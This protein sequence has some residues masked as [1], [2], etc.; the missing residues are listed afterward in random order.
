MSEVLIGSGGVLDANQIASLISQNLKNGERAKLQID[1]TRSPTAEFVNWLQDRL[2]SENIPGVQVS[3]GSP[4]LNISWIHYNDPVGYNPDDP[5]GPVMWIQV[6]MAVAAIIVSIAVIIALVIGWRIYKDIP[7]IVKGPLISG[8]LI[9]G[10]I[11][12]LAIA[13]RKFIPEKRR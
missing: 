11:L 9:A 8:V 3:T 4:I 7:D 13:Y 12:T 6:V 5:D 10:I 2:E 1:L